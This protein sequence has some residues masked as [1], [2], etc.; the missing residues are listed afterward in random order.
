MVLDVTVCA[1][2]LIRLHVIDSMAAVRVQEDIR[3]NT[4]H[5]VC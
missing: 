1:C 5:K 3:A 4:A 2:V